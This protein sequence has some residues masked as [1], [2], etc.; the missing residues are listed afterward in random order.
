MRPYH[1]L[2]FKVALVFSVLTILLLVSQ[3]LGVKTLAEVQEEKFITALIADDMAS[4]I[5]SYRMDPTLVPPFDRQLGGHVSQEGRIHITLPTSVKNLQNGIHEI[6][7]GGQ[8]IHVAIA[9]FDQARVYRV[10]DFSAYEK[11]F[12]KMINALMA[13][14]GLFA[15]LT[16][17]LAFGLSG[18]LVRQVAGLA[19]QVKAARLGAST[20]LNPGKYDE[21]EVADL[22]EA[23]NDY[24]DRMGQMIQREKEFTSNVSHEFR[25][26]LT[27]IKTSCELLAQNATM[28]AKSKA[29][30]RQ[31]DRAADNMIE[32]INALLLLAREESSANVGP[33][34]LIGAINDA[35]DPFADILATRNIVV[36]IDID[37]LLRVEVNRSALA[38]VLSNLIDNAARHSKHGRIRFSYVDGWLRIADTGRGIPPHDLAHVFERFYQARPAQESGHTFGIGLAIVKKISDRYRW[39][40]EIDSTPG[41]GTCVSLSLPQVPN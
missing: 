36:V 24:H 41:K 33:I 1:S 27:A 40:I 15:L 18:I 30:L 16:I 11:H 38:I 6:R 23:F 22:V 20:P 32:L 21:A 2:R 14:T 35:L 26:P 9:S 28:D 34:S 31:I 7:M 10:Y 25:T 3:A 29:R 8:E 37:S 12:K 39:S 17:W 19:R 5:Q 13:G 4:L